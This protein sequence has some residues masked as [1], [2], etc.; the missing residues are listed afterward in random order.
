MKTAFGAWLDEQFANAR[1]G[2]G[3]RIDTNAARAAFLKLPPLQLSRLRTGFLKLRQPRAE[4][5][6]ER[7]ASLASSGEQADRKERLLREMLRLDDEPVPTRRLLPTIDAAI[8]LFERLSRPNV[9]LC[10]EYR[11]EPRAGYGSKFETIGELAG[12]AIAKGLHFAMFQPFGSDLECVSRMTSL[13]IA[14]RMGASRLIDEVRNSFRKMLEAACEEGKRDGVSEEDVRKRLVLYERNSRRDSKR[15]DCLGPVGFQSRLFYARIPRE[16]GTD[17][18]IWEWVS[19][20]PPRDDPDYPDLFVRREGLSEPAVL[21]Q[22]F[23]VT[24]YWEMHKTLPTTDA[25]LTAPE[26]R[27]WWEVT[28]FE[29]PWTVFVDGARHPQGKQDVRSKNRTAARTRPR[30]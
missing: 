7:L 19:M 8:D 13:P 27:N 4:Q 16:Y 20:R 28:R 15:V 10:V 17:V 6:A 9:L 1:D 18:E 14:V 21:Q 12:K 5:I 11:D 22:F 2:A 23:P 24:A 29:N 3:A 30:S 26:L 25:E